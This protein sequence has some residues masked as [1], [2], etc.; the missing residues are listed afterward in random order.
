MVRDN[1]GPLLDGVS[2]G[3]Q[4]RG[5]QIPA[6]KKSY[7]VTIGY[8]SDERTLTNEEIEEAQARA[9]ASARHVEPVT[10]HLDLEVRSRVVGDRPDLRRT[11]GIDRGRTCDRGQPVQR[12]CHVTTADVDGKVAGRLST[13][14]TGERTGS[15]V[16]ARRD[17]LN[18]VDTRRVGLGGICGICCDSTTVDGRTRNQLVRTSVR[19]GGGDAIEGPFDGEEAITLLADLEA[20][21]VSRIFQT[22]NGYEIVKV[23]DRRQRDQTREAVR[24]EAR[25]ALGEQKSEEEG[26]LW[27]RKLRDEAYVDIRMPG[28]QS[29]PTAGGG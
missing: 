27:L 16:Q 19:R 1:A 3:G 17:R 14:T 8:R 21:E 26:Q 7:V 20:G 9:L 4:Y 11:C 18:G 23:E 10:G 24:A 6:D 2:F 29:T 13:V 22:G 5:Q 28:Y 12:G 15:Q 25:Q